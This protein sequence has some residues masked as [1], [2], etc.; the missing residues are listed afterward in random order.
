MPMSSALS[1]LSDWYGRVKKKSNDIVETTAAMAPAARPPAAAARIT[2]IT[3]TSTMFAATTL[4]SRNATKM[5]GDEERSEAR[6]RE[7]EG[8]E[9]LFGD[10]AAL[11]V[12]CHD[13]GI[14]TRSD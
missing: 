13:S 4:S 3:N 9:P 8:L 10:I 14:P 5:P 6:D 12:L 11:S 2:T 1:I 7:P